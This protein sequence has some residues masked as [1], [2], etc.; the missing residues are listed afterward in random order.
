M[1]VKLV[2]CVARKY[3]IKLLWK[4]CLPDARPRGGLLILQPRLLQMV[5]VRGRG[6]QPCRVSGLWEVRSLE[7]VSELE[8]DTIV[9]NARKPSETGTTT[10]K[11]DVKEGR[12]RG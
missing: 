10:F 2:S 12:G 6:A 11:F 1:Y 9:L 8:L 7:G 5:L 3:E 4:G